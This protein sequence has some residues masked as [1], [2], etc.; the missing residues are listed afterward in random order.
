MAGSPAG[1]GAGLGRALADLQHVDLGRAPGDAADVGQAPGPVGERARHHDLRQIV[2]ARV[3]DDGVGDVVL[4]Q[5]R[6]GGAQLFSQPQGHQD[7]LA[8]RFGQALQGRRLHVDGMPVRAQ[9]AG[10]AGGA[11]H[12]VFGVGAGADAGEQRTA[13]LPHGVDRLFDAVGAHVVFDAVGGAAQGQFAQGDQ[14]AL[15]E[16]AARGPLGLGRLVH[17]AFLEPGQQRS[18]R[19]DRPAPLRR[20]CRTRCRAPFR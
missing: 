14:V 7:A 8:L 13:G 19:A 20:R 17:L 5:H 4:G 2:V 12:H 3:A 6:R 9:L 11:A 1:A 18:R 10:Q 15:A 16:E